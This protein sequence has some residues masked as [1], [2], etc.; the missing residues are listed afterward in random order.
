L[1]FVEQIFQFFKP[2]RPELIEIVNPR[3]SCA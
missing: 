3:T 1:L 2:P